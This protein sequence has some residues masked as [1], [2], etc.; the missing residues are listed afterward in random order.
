MTETACAAVLAI[1]PILWIGGFGG[2]R[3]CIVNRV[4]V[5]TGSPE[6]RASGMADRDLP[7]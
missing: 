4:A 6:R 3:Y 5:A 7:A 1:G 2:G